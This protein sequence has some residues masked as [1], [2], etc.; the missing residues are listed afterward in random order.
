[1][2]KLRIMYISNGSGLGGAMQSMLDMLVGLTDRVSPMVVLPSTGVAETLLKERMIPYHIVPFI[3]AYGKIGKETQ[4]IVDSIFLDNYRASVRIAALIKKENIQ[5][6]HSNSIVI[7]VGA[8]AAIMAGVKH[9]WHIR[10]LLEEDFDSELYDKEWSCR[11]FGQTDRFIAISNCVS[12]SYAK[13]YGI[14]P[15]HL[16]DGMDID[17]YKQNIDNTRPRHGDHTFLLAGN[18]RYEKG[19]WDAVQAFEILTQSGEKNIRLL[20]VGNGSRKHI[21]GLER[22]IEARGLQ[23][24]I[25][26]LPV[27][28]DLSYFRE[29]CFFSLTTSRMEALGRVTIEAL[30]AG[31]IVIGSDTGGTVEILGVSQQYG[32]LYQEGDPEDLAR[33]IKIAMRETD[34]KRDDLRRRAQDFAIKQFDLRK[35]AKNILEQYEIVL[36]EEKRACLDGFLKKMND[37]YQCLTRGSNDDAILGQEKVNK[38]Y[39]QTLL[40]EKWL[41]L[42]QKGHSLVQYF[43]DDDIK[44]IAIYGMGNAG[45]DLYEELKNSDVRVACMIDK[46]PC[47]TG[48]TIKVIRPGDMLEEVD[49]VVVT[50]S[51]EEN[52]IKGYLDGLYPYKVISLRE[53]IDRMEL[54]VGLQ[55]RE[56][57]QKH[58]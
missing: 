14:S 5:I 7:N 1:M 18:I 11:L 31:N 12:R 53:I 9:I 47:Y 28:K 37:R 46:E 15:V 51:G 45:C 2:D 36:K 10:E 20:I 22:Y 52:E 30:L 33:V 25:S 54:N 48:N 26:I 42:K 19:Q 24:Y 56:S 41:R 55:D 50:V 29:R 16:Y 35:Y 27:Q 39:Q 8:M 6:V 32:Y 21:W 40:F 34:E 49:A 44:A 43:K 4:E 38:W 57:E 13:K 23:R 17:R 58:T 3:M